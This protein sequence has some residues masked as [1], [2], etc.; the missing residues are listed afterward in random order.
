M[1]RVE[2]TFTLRGQLTAEAFASAQRLHAGRISGCL[3]PAVVVVFAVAMNGLGIYLAS[4]EAWPVFLAGVGFPLAYVYARR[5][6][7]GH[8]FRQQPILALPQEGELTQEGLRMRSELGDVTIPWRFLFRV[9]ANAQVLLLYE[10]PHNFIIIP[11]HFFTHDTDFDLA[12]E[13]ARVWSREA[14]VRAA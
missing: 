14:Q 5:R 13:C 1:A 10:S 7:L 6:S 4:W 12:V 3:L 11:R 8:L 2:R 9:K